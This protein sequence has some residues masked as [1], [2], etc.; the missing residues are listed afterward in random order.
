[1]KTESDWASL[2]FINNTF[3]LD[4]SDFAFEFL[5]RNL[6]YQSDY[7]AISKGGPAA[8]ALINSLPTKWGLIFPGRSRK[9]RQFLPPDLAS[10]P[11]L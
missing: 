10:R 1:M 3:S 9:D 11:P 7:T 4:R 6:N 8:A 5:R 2:E